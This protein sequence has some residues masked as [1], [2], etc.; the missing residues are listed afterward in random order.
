MSPTVTISSKKVF[1]NWILTVIIGS[2]IWPMCMGA[3][4][5]F[6]MFISVIISGAWSLPALGIFFLVNAILNKPPAYSLRKSLIIHNGIHLLIAAATF[7]VFNVLMRFTGE[8]IL[9]GPVYT[10]IGLFVWNYTYWKLAKRTRT[11]SL[12]N[13]S[14]PT[15]QT[16]NT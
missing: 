15:D 12:E 3:P 5:P 13:T 16:E 14:E 9:I 6:V 1:Q 8:Y 4:H 7:S 11:V 2:V 10:V